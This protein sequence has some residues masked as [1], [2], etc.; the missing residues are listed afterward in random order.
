MIRCNSFSRGVIF[1]PESNFLFLLREI[2]SL[3]CV[4]PTSM[5]RIFFFMIFSRRRG[6]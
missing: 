3:T 5:T 2:I 6:T 1:G 4:P